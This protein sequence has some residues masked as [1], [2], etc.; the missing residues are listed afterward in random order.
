MYFKLKYI[1]GLFNLWEMTYYNHKLYEQG[2]SDWGLVSWVIKISVT[3]GGYMVRVSEER[4]LS[5]NALSW[6]FDN[7]V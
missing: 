5:I 2:C 7:I 3:Q 4:Q 1:E 6:Y